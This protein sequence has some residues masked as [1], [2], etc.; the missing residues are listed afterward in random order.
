MLLLVVAVAF[1]AG[2]SAFGGTPTPIPGDEI[3]TATVGTDP[4]ATVPQPPV[5]AATAAV[6]PL[7][8]LTALELSVLR[9]TKQRIVT[10]G[11][12][13]WHWQ[14]LMGLRRSHFSAAAMQTQSL[15]YAIWVLKLRQQLAKRLHQYAKSWMAQRVTAMKL[16]VNHWLR[17][18]GKQPVRE[19][20]SSGS[21]EAQFNRWSQT[22]HSVWRQFSNPPQMSAFLCIHRFE[23]A[24]NDKNS[25]GNG[26]YGGVQFGKNEWLR[27]GYPYTGK[28]WAYQA[29]PIEQLW[30]AYRYWLVSGFSPWPQTAHDCG[31]L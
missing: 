16:S 27:F 21:I 2:A 26:H 8:T 24:W 31:L 3:P 13:V 28:L 22:S 25:G 18:M 12:L 17:V 29:T 20:A 11:K 23:G 1:G 14:T 4:A 9:G 15:P 6:T 30:A 5:T 10:Y 7:P 19:L